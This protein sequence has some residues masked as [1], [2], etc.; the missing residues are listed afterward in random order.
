[1]KR[2][3]LFLLLNAFVMT[4]IQAQKPDFLFMVEQAVKAPS[5]HNTQPWLFKIYESSLEIR[6]NMTKSLSV[7]DPDN[8]ELFI[9]LGCAAE[10]VCLAAAQK[11]YSTS[12]S[13][14]SDGVITIELHKLDG[15]EK[16]PLFAQ[17]PIRQTNRSVYRGKMIPSDTVALLKKIPM[18]DQVQLYAYANKSREFEIVKLLVERGNTLQMKDQLFTDELK[19]WMR[20]N[21]SSSKKTGDGLSYY[22]VGA[23][24]MP[25]FIAKPLVGSYLTPEKQNKGD[26]EKIESSS[27]IVLLTTKH[28]TIG[29]WVA[30]GRSLQRVLLQTTAW[31]IANAYLN[32]PCE[33]PQ[34]REE[35]KTQLH[36]PEGEYPTILLRIGYA[37]KVPYSKR[38]DVKESLL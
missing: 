18:L 29:E 19:S 34:L 9:S 5:G 20:F 13:V 6:P 15:V 10:N 36:L 30:L 22:S 12:V 1:M 7:V 38:K 28:N 26:M 27:H 14:A 31:N 25:T 23:P 35:L 17:I 2:F 4:Q 24:S 21:E 8:R 33:L 32:Q 11:G 16:S 3:I 37:E